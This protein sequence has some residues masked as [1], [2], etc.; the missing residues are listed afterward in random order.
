MKKFGVFLC[1]LFFIAFVRTED[2]PVINESLNVTTENVQEHPP[3]NSTIEHNLQDSSHEEVN[4]TPD[5]PVTDVDTNSSDYYNDDAMNPEGGYE[6]INSN[7]TAH[8][9]EGI[10][11]YN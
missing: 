4:K 7:Y 2:A 1:L 3:T 6:E 8:Q 9:E 11:L 5:H 10:F